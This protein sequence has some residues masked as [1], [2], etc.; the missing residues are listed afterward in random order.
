MTKLALI[1]DGGKSNSSLEQLSSLDASKGV[2]EGSS[3]VMVSTSVIQENKLDES[4][5]KRRHYF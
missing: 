3:T 2:V 5:R 1:R 4:K